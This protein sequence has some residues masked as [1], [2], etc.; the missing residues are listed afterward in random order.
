MTFQEGNITNIY[1]FAFV[2]SLVITFIVIAIQVKKNLKGTRISIRRSTIFL[3]YYL[4][5]VSYLIYNSFNAGVP[6]PYVIPYIMIIVL[7]GF[8]AYLYSKRNLVFWKNEKK[9]LYVKGGMLIYFIYLFALITRI[10]INLFFVGFQ[11]VHLNE[12][13]KIITISHPIIHI[14]LKTKILSLILTDSLIA[15]GAGLL[16]GRYY[17]VLELIRH[18]NTQKV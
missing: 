7:S 16:I 2:V 3:I 11:E 1:I 15:L 4:L 8:Y 12:F 6:Y 10:I 18:P 17:R 13:G 14:G 5:I 9:D